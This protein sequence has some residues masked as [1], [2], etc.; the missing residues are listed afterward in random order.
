M[1]EIVKHIGEKFDFAVDF[2][3]KLPVNTTIVSGILLACQK[4]TIQVTTLAA[5]CSAGAAT[6]SVS[7]NVKA[8]AVLT[9]N[10]GGVVE[11]VVLVSSVS[12]A[13][14]YI[15]TLASAVQVDHP[16]GEAME[17]DP[18]ATDLLLASSTPAIS[19][20]LMKANVIGGLVGK[21]MIIFLA[22]TNTGKIIRE[23]V[24][25]YVKS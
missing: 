1:L 13:G 15:A 5:G 20:S 4:E 8:G 14:P 10:E 9:L 2:S 19:G 3:P 12:G 7:V 6:V 24:L 23:D 21:Y 18:G 16:S 22:T 11:E 17:Y 25:V